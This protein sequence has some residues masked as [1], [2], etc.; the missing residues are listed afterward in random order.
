MLAHERGTGQRQ[1]G[2]NEHAILPA[3]VVIYRVCEGKRKLQVAY[4]DLAKEELGRTVEEASFVINEFK[5][6]ILLANNKNAEAFL[7]HID[8][9]RSEKVI[10]HRFFRSNVLLLA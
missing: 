3:D 6:R 2:G 9:M 1:F 4:E 10:V 5:R 8:R 7:T